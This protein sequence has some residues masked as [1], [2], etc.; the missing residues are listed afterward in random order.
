MAYMGLALDIDLSSREFSEFMVSDRMYERYA[1]TIGIGYEFA[2]KLYKK[3]MD[4]FG[5]KNFVIICAGLLS[6]TGVPAPKAVSITKNPL[7]STFGPGVVGGK[8]A[9]DIKRAGYDLILIRGI[10]DSPVVLKVTSK[11]VEF[12]TASRLWG[13]DILK[14][15]ETLKKKEKGSCIVIGPAGENLVPMSLA[16]VDGVHH[17]GRGGLAAVLGAKKV[18]AIIVEGDKEVTIFDKDWFKELSKGLR[19]RINA[20]KLRKLYSEM[21]VMVAWDEWAK[22]GYLTYR[23]RSKKAPAGLIS[24]FGVEKFLR[25]IKVK[26]LGCYGCPSP[27]KAELRMPNGKLRKLPCIWVLRY[28]WE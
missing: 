3:K 24:E 14:V 9:H 20:D 10:S 13:K 23:M 4:P 22:H 27:C 11:G 19:E 8:L 12:R 5:E 6:A 18:K 7:N 16:L 15:T 1:G 26:S 17:L 2:T 21:G 28:L 25:R